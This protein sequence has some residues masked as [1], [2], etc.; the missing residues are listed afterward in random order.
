MSRWN[1]F[2]PSRARPLRDLGEMP[3]SVC[4]VGAGSLGLALAAALCRAGVRVTLVAR[5]SSELVLLQRGAIEVS[6][7]MQAAANVTLS[8]GPPSS[9]ALSSRPAD[10]WS[11]E[12][13][14]LTVKG[15]D[16]PSVV[17]QLAAARPSSGAGSTY[18]IG[19]QNGVIKDQIL[20]EAFGPERVVGG[21]TLLGC[22][23]VEPWSVIVSGSG[24]TF[25]G[26]LNDIP[27]ARVARLAADLHNAGLP[28][29]VEAD[30][31]SL[32]WTKFCHAIGVFGVSALTGLPSYDIFRRPHLAHVYLS[33][34]VEAA[35]VAESE[36]AVIADFPGLPIE[37]NLRLQASDA[38]ARMTAWAGDQKPGPP[39]L[40]SLAQDLAAGRQTEVEETF[41]DLVS[42]AKAHDLE[43]PRSELVY[44]VVRGHQYGLQ[45]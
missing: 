44:R 32:L 1:S 8:P 3:S 21:A 35:A 23:R 18:F 14:L 43:V 45:E 31:H 38:V 36:G 34:L 9:I 27:S 28:V 17:R 2:L 15:P 22:Q 10:A 37:T 42:R 33:L 20:I 4:I 29:K 19:L 13:V 7:V 26:E 6:G 11:S 16:L 12:A 24:T 25:L 40:S 5:A 41:G 30:I 39:A